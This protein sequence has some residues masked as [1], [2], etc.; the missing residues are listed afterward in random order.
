VYGSGS[1]RRIDMTMQSRPDL[2]RAKL[3]MHM[4]QIDVFRKLI[5]NNVAKW[6]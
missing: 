5:P 4:K 3:A 6:S 1:E 2:Q